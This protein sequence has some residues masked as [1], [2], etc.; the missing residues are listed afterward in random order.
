MVMV[1]LIVS[2]IKTVLPVAINSSCHTN[3]VHRQRI[4]TI[5]DAE[6]RAGLSS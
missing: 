2:S 4:R 6:I 5:D 3:V 1:V